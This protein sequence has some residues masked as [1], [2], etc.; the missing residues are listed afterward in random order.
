AELER[1]LVVAG[2][3]VVDQA[4]RAPDVDEVLSEQ[5]VVAGHGLLRVRAHRALDLADL[6]L[7]VLVAR[8]KPKAAFA[9]DLEVAALDLEHV[10][11][12]EE[13]APRVQPPACSRDRAETV[14]A[15]ELL[16]VYHLALEEADDE[17]VVLAE[18]GD[19]RRSDARLGGRD[20]VVHL[21]L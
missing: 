1:G 11:V 7:E 9:H 21:V 4:H 17:R 13:A 3:L 12:A 19:E 18:R 16:R 2:V 8:R 6:R 14:A 5:V 15:A 20:R 10:E